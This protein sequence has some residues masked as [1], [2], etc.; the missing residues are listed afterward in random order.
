MAAASAPLTPPPTPDG[1][2]PPSPAQVNPTS[3]PAASPAPPVPSPA[4]QNGTQLAIQVVSNLRSIAQAFPATAAK[5][6][7]INNLMREVVAGMMTSAHTGE[8]AAPPSNG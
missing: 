3:P 7:E 5:V 8:P 4:M 2:G 6:A 1:G